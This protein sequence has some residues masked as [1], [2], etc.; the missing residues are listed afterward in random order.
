[1]VLAIHSAVNHRLKEGET[2]RIN[3]KPKP[4]S[5]TGMLS[6]AGLSGSAKPKPLSLGLAP[7][8][9]AGKIKSP[10]PPPPHG[11][12]AARSISGGVKLPQ[13]NQRGNIL[14]QVQLDGW[15]SDCVSIC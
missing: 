2:I 10:L 5:E 9:G 1:M 3:V 7:P 4:T 11:P 13:H 6:A 8:P 14:Q 12:V 15:L